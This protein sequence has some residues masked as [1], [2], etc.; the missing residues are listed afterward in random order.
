MGNRAVITTKNGFNKNGV[1]IYVHW[2]GG[3]D[4]VEA[5]LEYCRLSGFR[6]PVEDS[7]YAMARLCGVIANFMGEDG[8][9]VGIDTVSMLDTD[10]DD[11]GTYIIGKDW[12]IVGR[13]FHHGKE[14]SNYP[15]RGMLLEIN[16]KMP[17]AFDISDRIEA[18]YPYDGTK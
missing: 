14:Q 2:N 9:S 18:A 1:G 4:S 3:R 8:L 16:R 12:K 7:G 5:F 11:N 15:M 6:D 10:N 17:V 13:K